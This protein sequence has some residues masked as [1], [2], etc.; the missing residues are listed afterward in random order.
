MDESL[1]TRMR[2][3]NNLWG[4]GVLGRL[5]LIFVFVTLLSNEVV[6][7]NVF[8]HPLIEVG[9]G[10]GSATNPFGT[11][12]EALHNTTNG[13]VI[14]LYPGTYEGEGNVNLQLPI[15]KAVILVSASGSPIDTIIDGGNDA[16]AFA[17][18][19]GAQLTMS[20]ITLTHF[21]YATGS[22]FHTILSNVILV[23]NCVFKH[24][25]GDN[26]GMISLGLNSQAT[27]SGCHFQNMTAP[28]GPVFISNGYNAGI[29][30]G[31][32]F[33][34][35]YGAAGIDNIVTSFVHFEGNTVRRTVGMLKMSGD[36]VVQHNVFEDSHKNTE[37][38]VVTLRAGNH[39]VVGN[40]FRN[41]TASQGGAIYLRGFGSINATQNTFI[42]NTATYG[43][44]GG[45]I[46]L[47]LENRADADGLVNAISI[48]NNTFMY[49]A[50]QH[51]GG[52]IL[53]ESTNSGNRTIHDNTFIG[54]SAHMGGAVYSHLGNQWEGLTVSLTVT[55]CVFKKNVAF[56]AGSVLAFER[57]FGTRPLELTLDSCVMEHNFID[58]KDHK[59]GYG[60]N[61]DDHNGYDYHDDDG[62]TFD[63]QGHN[64]AGLSGA[65]TVYLSAK[66]T[67]TY[68]VDTYIAH[69]E[70]DNGTGIFVLEGTVHL[71]GD[72]T[73]KN[74]VA[75][76][77]GGAI[78]VGRDASVVGL[79]GES[80]N[81]RAR[82]ASASSE[83]KDNEAYIGG[84][85][86]FFNSISG[87]DDDDD[88]QSSLKC[89]I[90][91]G[92]DAAYGPML[93]TPAKR[94]K[95]KTNPSGKSTYNADEIKATVSLL[96]SYKQL[97][98]GIDLEFE[99]EVE[100]ADALLID[101]DYPKNDAVPLEHIES[102]KGDA[103][104]T[105]GV[106][107]E[108]GDKYT[109]SY[110]VLS[111]TG[112]AMFSSSKISVKDCDDDEY[113]DEYPPGVGLFYVCEDVDKVYVST[114][115]E[116]LQIVFGILAGIGIILV[117]VSAA[118]IIVFRERKA[119]NY[120]SPV[121][122]LMILFGVLLGYIAVVLL[123]VE[124]SDG[125]CICIPIFIV[126]AFTFSIGPLVVKNW[127]ILKLFGNASFQSSM[128]MLS[129]P[130][131]YCMVGAIVAINTGLLIWW[132][133]WSTPSAEW[134]FDDD[135]DDTHILECQSDHTNIVVVVI[136]SV[137]GILLLFA[138]YL[139]FRTRAITKG[140]NESRWI[141][142]AIYAIFYVAVFIVPLVLVL[143]DS[144][145]KL[146]LVV[147]GVWF[148]TTALLIGLFGHKFW[149]IIRA[150]D[151]EEQF[152]QESDVTDMKETRAFQ[153]ITHL[154]GSSGAF[155]K[156]AVDS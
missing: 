153:T 93:A 105:F 17:F 109:L 82:Q 38:G 6:S 71:L 7:D 117:F 108:I 121:F 89:S 72:T 4:K 36:S 39:Q 113:L 19:Y 137:N 124:P 150:L 95:V 3:H 135:T 132:L 59:N 134:E 77:Y 141:A 123:V 63:N 48:N 30:V 110:H 76:E 91:N 99:I 102:S 57:G 74:N 25:E 138:A 46:C 86:V 49:N 35:L 120:A 26:S 154:G 155:R 31:C 107:G 33:E 21:K 84:G 40:I 94:L 136:G 13:D 87:D 101:L 56:V 114:T 20:G 43:I 64:H 51:E 10:T 12:L 29:F 148:C 119:I 127:R 47:A 8:V 28:V 2:I 144:D 41:N 27:F 70:A 65:G 118:L 44:G 147:F 66:N 24:F 53:L 45:A 16:R 104:F 142:L 22:G 11:I 143:D 131:L 145:F 42:G 9:T 152:G 106:V 14:V 62:D 129:N 34:D 69:N 151:K 149:V 60:N 103:S 140:F 128:R 18:D 58:E 37:G 111:D 79:N 52:A 115:R 122:L 125:V 88:D 126:Y 156:P 5:F 55:N 75:H 54:N 112:L 100:P 92:N 15:L 61:H 116:V 83:I 80:G 68:V 98:A 146:T 67:E 97:V 81:R 96:D 139:A 85:A 90:C 32:V 73:F 50:A 1:L 130:A 23:S 78:F 133:V